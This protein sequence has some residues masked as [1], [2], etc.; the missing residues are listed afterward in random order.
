MDDTS[1]KPPQ[2]VAFSSLPPESSE[3]ESETGRNHKGFGL[4]APVID[5]FDH[6]RK[7]LT[8]FTPIED[9]FEKGADLLMEEASK[10]VIEAVLKPKKEDTNSGERGKAANNKKKSSMVL[11]PEY[12]LMF[13]SA[14][15]PE[16][17]PDGGNAKG[18]GEKGVAS[19]GGNAKEE[20]QNVVLFRM[21]EDREAKRSE[22]DQE[23]GG[24]TV[25][26]LGQSESREQRSWTPPR[27][28]MVNQ[29][30]MW[31]INGGKLADTVITSS[32]AKLNKS[33]QVATESQA[34]T[35]PTN[36]SEKYEWDSVY[37][38]TDIWKTV[39]E[40]MNS[41]TPYG[42]RTETSA[43]DLAW[44][45]ADQ[46]ASIFRKRDLDPRLQFMQMFETEINEIA[47]DDVQAAHNANNVTIQALNS[48]SI[49]RK[50]SCDTQKAPE[51]PLFG[52][53]DVVLQI[54][55]CDATPPG[56]SKTKQSLAPEQKTKWPKELKDRLDKFEDS[57]ESFSQA[58]Q[59]STEPDVQHSYGNLECEL[60]QILLE[61]FERLKEDVKNCRTTR[62][63][64]EKLDS[65]IQPSLDALDC[66]TD[67][68]MDKLF[69]I[70][71]ETKP[72][73]DIKD[74]LEELN[75]IRYIGQQQQAVIKPF[76]EHLYNAADATCKAESI[77]LFFSRDI[78]HDI[79]LREQLRDL[80]DLKQKQASVIEARFARKRMQAASDDAEAT[81][82]LTYQAVRQGW[83][84]M[85][86]TIVTIIFL[87]LSFFSSLF[88]VNAKE[89]VSGDYSLVLYSEIMYPASLFIICLSLGLAFNINFRFLF[90]LAWRKI[91]EWTGFSAF[92]RKSLGLSIASNIRESI[93]KEKRK[94]AA[95]NRFRK[96]ELG[97]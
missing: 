65:F 75:I 56:V 93:E 4:K 68:I 1:K 73:K 76:T 31:K 22:K 61:L 2:D 38:P 13:E 48:G 95:N 5:I 28:M 39:R 18:K 84:I 60:K 23:M 71:N 67:M 12:W 7:F 63:M 15:P 19:E 3:E 8:C 32:S 69:D 45:I 53:Y 78:Y 34:P 96:W 36:D 58:T 50:N 90:L 42:E 27:I 47:S 59:A 9:L 21:K 30:W 89:F 24:E 49:D 80:L 70:T 14:I 77:C 57:V 91:F 52:K 72:V 10:H 51:G 29:L 85:L 88:G 54:T 37:D 79:C 46:A 97:V 11:G 6:G 43:Y 66:Y 81:T 33:D 55:A 40:K 83:S 74:I 35:S 20:S 26:N 82:S 17:A 94:R 41:G 62:S 44:T 25:K 86:F 64:N 16:E 92:W 87:P